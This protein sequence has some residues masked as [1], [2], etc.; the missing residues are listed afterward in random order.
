M[1]TLL[2]TLPREPAAIAKWLLVAYAA[3]VLVLLGVPAVIALSAGYPD[4]IL[5]S[6]PI[7][8]WIVGPAALAAL[9]AARA[10]STAEAWLFVGAESAGVASTAWLSA[11]LFLSTGSQNAQSGIALLILPLIQ[12]AAVLP[13]ASAVIGTALILRNR[14]A[15]A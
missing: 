3:G 11:V 9:L 2:K 7:L 6:V 1:K 8:A 4:V 15:R 14:S 12:W 10:K 5:S 13:Y